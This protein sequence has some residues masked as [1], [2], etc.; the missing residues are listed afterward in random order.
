MDR[1]QR[2]ELL[3]RRFDLLCVSRAKRDV[4]AL[5]QEHA[6]DLAPDALRAAR[7]DHVLTGQTKFHVAPPVGWMS[8]V[9]AELDGRPAGPRLRSAACSTVAPIAQ[10]AV[11]AR[12]PDL[13]VDLEP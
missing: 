3:H 1:S 8:P 2:R 12:L 7:D 9:H 5:G 4:R 6:A 13:V 11:G 10:L